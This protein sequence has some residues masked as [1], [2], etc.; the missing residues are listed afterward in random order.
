MRPHC[1]RN[2]T[3][4]QYKQ[5]IAIADNFM[6]FIKCEY[7]VCAIFNATNRNNPNKN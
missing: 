3:G 5:L 2:S 7:N 6:E 4:P 1:G